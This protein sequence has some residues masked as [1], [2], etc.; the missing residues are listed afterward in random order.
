MSRMSEHA[1]ERDTGVYGDEGDPMS[2]PVQRPVHYTMMPRETIDVIR[3]T[4]G[5]SGFLAYCVG[6]ALKYLSRAPF[7]GAAQD[8]AKAAWYC[9]M[10]AHRMDPDTYPDPRK[11]RR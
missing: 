3:D 10:A 11:A 7:K 4:L 1:H 5:E 8:Y 6:N 9:Q 2:D